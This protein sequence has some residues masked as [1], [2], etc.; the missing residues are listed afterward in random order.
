M[1]IAETVT[2]VALGASSTFFSRRATANTRSISNGTIGH[3]KDSLNDIKSH[4]LIQDAHM[5]RQDQQVGEIAR[6]LDWH[7]RVLADLVENGK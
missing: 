6:K 3:M 2:F 1:S 4:L 7:D 5:L